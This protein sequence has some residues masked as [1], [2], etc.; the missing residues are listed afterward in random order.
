M[1]CGNIQTDRTFELGVVQIQH[2]S[3]TKQGN[4][5]GIS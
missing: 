5:K 4:R 1:G 2:T 3:M